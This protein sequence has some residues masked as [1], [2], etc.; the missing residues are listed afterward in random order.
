MTKH[1]KLVASLDKISAGLTELGIE[2]DRIGPTL[3]WTITHPRGRVMR[4]DII[5][6]DDVVMVESE[7]WMPAEIDPECDEHE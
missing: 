2:H 3:E 4:F 7:L 1:K 6:R 5:I